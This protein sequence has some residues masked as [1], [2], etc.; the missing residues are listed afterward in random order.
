MRD[1]Q[2]QLQ[3]HSLYRHYKGNLYYVVGLAEHSETNELMVVYHALYGDNEMWVRPL[4][5]FLSEVEEGKE[6]PTGQKYRFELAQ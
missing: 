5:M 3:Q 6:N 1:L 4:E 2:F